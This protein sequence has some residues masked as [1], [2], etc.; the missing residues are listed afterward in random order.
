MRRARIVPS[1]FAAVATWMREAWRRLEPMI[2]SSRS[3]A[4]M[5]GRSSR[6]AATAASEPISVATSSLPPNEPPVYA[7]TTRTL[8]AGTPRLAAMWPLRWKGDWQEA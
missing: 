2:D 3:C 8:E 4:I 5:T 6:R 1:F 7:C